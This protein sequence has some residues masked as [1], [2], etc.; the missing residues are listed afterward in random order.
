MMTELARRL[1][2]HLPSLCT[3]PIYSSEEEYLNAQFNHQVF[4][5]YSVRNLSDLKERSMTGAI[6]N[7]GVQQEYSNIA[8]QNKDFNPMMGKLPPTEYPFW[9]ITPHHPYAFNS[10]FHFLNLH[11]EKEAFAVIHPQAAIDIGIT[12]GGIVKIY[13]DQACIEMK[14][15]CSKQVPKDIVMVYQGWYPDSDVTINDLIPAKQED[16]SKE[17]SIFKNDAFYDTFVNVQ[18]L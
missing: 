11:D 9:F 17:E 7:T 14:A 10:Q 15:L 18:K 12:N 3:F 5:R 8:K 2:Q 13:N 4:N 1:N 6:S 16:P